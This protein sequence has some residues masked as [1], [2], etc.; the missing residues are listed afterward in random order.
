MRNLRVFAIDNS[1]MFQNTLVQELTKRLPSGSLVEHAGQPA[2]ALDKMAVFKPDIIVL[3]FALGSLMVNQEKFLPLL[4]KKY[5]QV[6]IIT[7]GILESG[8]KAAKILGA[9]HYLKKPSV[10]QPMEPFLNNLMR[11]LLVSQSKNG[12]AAVTPPGDIGGGAVVTREIWRA[13]RPVQPPPPPKPAPSPIEPMINVPPNA[14]HIDLIA[15]GASTG[16]TEALSAIITK[17]EPPL[18]GIVIVQHIPPMFSKLFSERLNTESRLTVKEAVSG[19]VVLPNHVY[20]APGAKHMTISR[21]GTRYMLE[22]KPGPPVH[23][24]CPSV[25]VL[26]DSVADVAG[27]HAMGIILTGIGKDGA[28]GLL[29]MR[30]L[31]SPTIGQDAASSTVYGMPK[32]AFEMGAVQQQLPLLSIPDAICKIAR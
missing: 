9:A 25:D 8:E 10:G 22:C 1:I 2:E 11:T 4:A 30:Q 16:G 14:A 24:V 17:L 19:D 27:N 5:S 21:M 12:T 3:N 26:F 29:K 18:P 28:A 23:S 13:S 31:G 20:I 15:I 32:A 7:Y 6:P